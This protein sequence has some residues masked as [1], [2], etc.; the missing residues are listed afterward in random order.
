MPPGPKDL[1]A[2]IRVSALSV[3]WTVSASIV[4]M[5]TGFTSHTL[6]L[7]V[8]GLTGL[9]DA[10]GSLAI[11][12]HFRSALHNE[13]FSSARERFAL[14]VVSVGL[15]VVGAVTVIES[16]R[17]LL[18]RAHADRTPVGV[19]I[20]LASV[21]VLT[22]LTTR[23]RIV[24]RRVGSAALMADSWL[25]ATG[26]GLALIAVVGAQLSPRPGLYWID[27]LCALGIALVAVT[28]GVTA[29]RRE[30]GSPR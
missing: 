2:G 20:A 11:A 15:M 18:A 7:I 27:S 24:A 12:L 13:A 3:A 25:S 6:V 29:G 23:K 9:V 4:A 19:A 17:R 30:E 21:I 16:V 10:A 26:A 8:F 28:V 14:R 1:R 5:V 22:L